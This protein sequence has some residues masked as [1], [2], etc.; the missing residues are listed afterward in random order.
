MHASYTRYT[1]KGGAHRP[2]G[3]RT[4]YQAV[5][6][7]EHEDALLDVVIRVADKA[8][9]LEPKLP[10]PVPLPLLPL[11]L[12]RPPR[13]PLPLPLPHSCLPLRLRLRPRRRRGVRALKLQQLPAQRLA[14]RRLD[15][16]QDACAPTLAALGGVQVRAGLPVLGFGFWFGVGGG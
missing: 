4:T 13:P 2:W 3:G 11:P 14:E 9:R 10:L 15:V 5:V 12:I 16:G 1:K 7:E 8:P 6:D